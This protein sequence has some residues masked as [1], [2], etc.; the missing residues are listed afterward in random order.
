MPQYKLYATTHGSWSIVIDA[1][2][3]SDA[4]NQAFNIPLDNWDSTGYEFTI[5]SL[6]EVNGQNVSID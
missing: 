6:E 5:D 2:S 3:I 1:E 4:Q